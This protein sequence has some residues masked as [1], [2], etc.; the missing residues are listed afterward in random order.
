MN[1]EGGGNALDLAPEI[2]DITEQLAHN[3]WMYGLNL[4]QYINGGNDKL[5]VYAS[6][7]NTD[8]DSYY[9]GLGGG[10]TPADS[11]L[12]ANAYGVTDDQSLVT[13][14]QWNH[15]SNEKHAL[16]GGVEYQLN[17]TDD[18]ISGY[19]RRVDQ[20]VNNWGVYGQ[21]E[22]QVSGNLKFLVG[23]RYDRSEVN[24]K[25][26]LV[27]IKNT[28][29]EDFN[30]L[31]PRFTVLFN[32]NDKIQ[33]RGGYA[34]GFRAPQAFN[35]D[36][37]ISSAGGEPVFVVLSNGLNKETSDA[38]SGSLNYTSK[39][40]DSQFNFNLQ[41]FHTQLNNPF[42]MVNTGVQLS[43]GS[44]VQEVRSGDG[45]YVSGINTEI[46][47]AMN[48]QWILQSGFTAQQ[49]KYNKEQVLYEPDL[50]QEGDIVV[51]D[52]FMRVPN[53]YGFLSLTN[54][55]LK[56]WEFS[57]SNVYTGPMK[58][59]EISQQDG[60][61]VIRES[62]NFWDATIKASHH[63]HLAEKLHITLSAGMQNIFNSFQTDFQSGPFRDSD[64]V[65]GP[66]RPRTFF[67]SL[68]LKN[69]D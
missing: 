34:R 65:Y 2:T 5:S 11:L 13:G 1:I 68:S 25:Y 28:I 37:H 16:T 45:A 24:G 69:N 30:V 31:S 44:I 21:W 18:Q 53:L 4:D 64:Y 6:W 8:R 42:V 66:R 19:Q 47:Y 14:M 39:R 17:H 57:F 56:D 40:G 50:P 59:P 51:S 48:R 38:L 36:L 26:E 61:L 29:K 33:F 43:N 55:S 58:V 22:W 54:T 63:F 60:R 27:D 3:I 49:A 46:N 32:L 62:Q 67:V 10:R 41:G 7:Q 35:E 9:G 20:I 12:A 52:D 15:L 23:L